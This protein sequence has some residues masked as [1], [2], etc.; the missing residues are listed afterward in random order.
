MEFATEYGEIKKQIKIK[1]FSSYQDKD[2][3]ISS[4][5]SVNVENFHSEWKVIV[6]PMHPNKQEEED[7]SPLHCDVFLELVCLSSTA[8]PRIV[9]DTN[10]ITL[11]KGR[12]HF[13]GILQS[14]ENSSYPTCSAWKGVILPRV[15]F[16]SSKLSQDD[17]FEF[18]II[19][20]I[21][22]ETLANSEDGKMAI[23]KNLETILREPLYYDVCLISMTGSKF[24]AHSAILHCRSNILKTAKIQSV[25]HEFSETFPQN[26]AEETLSSQDS[27]NKLNGNKDYVF[28]YSTDDTHPQSPLPT[29]QKTPAKNHTPLF[30]FSSMASSNSSSQKSNGSLSPWKSDALHKMSSASPLKRDFSSLSPSTPKKKNGKMKTP[31]KGTQMQLTEFFQRSSSLKTENCEAA[32]GFLYLS[33]IKKTPSHSVMSPLKI[34]KTLNSPL[35]SAS[36]MK[37]HP[38]SSRATEN[39]QTIRKKLFQTDQEVKVLTLNM[40]TSVLQELLTWIYIGKLSRIFSVIGL[41]VIKCGEINCD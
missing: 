9:K 26:G 19:F 29:Q 30:T 28:E 22:K 23:V 27:L 40:S 18:I 31:S 12:E 1:D 38:H 20:K 32:P 35:H 17:I 39:F 4:I 3:V 24:F 7:T 10:I 25:S 33:P 16:L 36:P 41:I 5:I 37:N 21:S 6:H 15:R 2:S 11:V 8:P 14:I 34:F 13:H